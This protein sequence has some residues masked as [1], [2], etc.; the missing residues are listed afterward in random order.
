MN[1]TDGVG[2]NIRA[3]RQLDMDSLASGGG[4]RGS[5]KEVPG[6]PGPPGA[7]RCPLQPLGEAREVRGHRNP[8]PGAS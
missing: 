1:V 7:H 2:I 5:L 8:H 3:V 6:H 4:F